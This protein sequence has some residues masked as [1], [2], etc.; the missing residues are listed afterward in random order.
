MLQSG[1]RFVEPALRA[2]GN[3]FSEE[4]IA[5]ALEMAG[6][7]LRG[8][9]TILA[10]EIDS[11]FAG[12]CLSGPTPLTQSTWHLYWMCVLPRFQRRGIGRALQTNLESIVRASGGRRLVL[13]TAGRADYDKARSFYRSVGYAECGRI[14]DYYSSGDDCF[15]YCKVLP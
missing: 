4:E 3:V 13:E 14:V 1:L 12:Y 9:Y 15:F 8:E 6:E 10:A 5:V 7:A 2:C 11:E